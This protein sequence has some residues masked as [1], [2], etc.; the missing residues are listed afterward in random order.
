MLGLAPR[1]PSII[2]KGPNTL[3][4]KYFH[5]PPYLHAGGRCREIG[6]SRSTDGQ[7]RGFIRPHFTGAGRS[8]SFAIG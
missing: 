8:E 5:Q 3:Q 4:W 2:L 7:G 6:S 1:P